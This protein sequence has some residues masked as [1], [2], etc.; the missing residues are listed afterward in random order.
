MR[1]NKNI[2]LLLICCLVILV[3]S[4]KAQADS[5]RLL[6][7][8]VDGKKVDRK[9]RIFLYV[10]NQIIEPQIVGDKFIVPPEIKKQQNVGVRFS[11]GKYNLLFDTVPT[12]SFNVDWII[13][14]D[15]KP[16]KQEYV[17]P[18]TAEKLK[19][20]YYITLVPKDGDET[21]LVV[22]LYK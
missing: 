11:C 1:R 10:N 16:F 3:G 14:V 17:E 13:G 9:F 5:V 21:R 6:R 18:Q 20:L 2:I 15:H 19:L 8:E 4:V 12:S 22:K 7:F